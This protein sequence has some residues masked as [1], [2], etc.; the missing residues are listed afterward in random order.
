VNKEEVHH[1]RPIPVVTLRH[2]LAL[3][4]HPDLKGTIG[5]RVIHPRHHEFD[6]RTDPDFENKA[7]DIVDVTSV[8]FPSVPIE[9][10]RRF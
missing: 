3:R 5:K 6:R 2:V 4:I 8:S 1:D 7:A 10:L 9:M